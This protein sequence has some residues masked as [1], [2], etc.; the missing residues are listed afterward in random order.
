MTPTEIACRRHKILQ[1]RLAGGELPDSEVMTAL[2]ELER[3]EECADR[4]T[5]SLLVDLQ[6]PEVSSRSWGASRS[7]PLAA[8]AGLLVGLLLGTWRARPNPGPLHEQP[9]LVVV[10]VPQW[11]TPPS[12]GRQPTDGVSLEALEHRRVDPSEET[13][14]L[15]KVTPAKEDKDTLQPRGALAERR[16]QQA[17]NEALELIVMRGRERVAE[18]LARV[19]DRVRL[20]THPNAGVVAICLERPNGEVERIRAE[21]H[22]GFVT[23]ELSL[24]A[25]G[26]HG[27]LLW[28]GAE[29]CPK[30]RQGESRWLEVNAGG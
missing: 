16:S 9:R 24:E 23:P 12:V 2:E 20:R 29:P 13:A 21:E 8:A 11:P 4:L 27:V 17:V 25:A 28:T 19:G 26:S 7:I 1:Q 22:G 14:P 6:P 30:L 18:D 10:E 15:A 3:C 5:L